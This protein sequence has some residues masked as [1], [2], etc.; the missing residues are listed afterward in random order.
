[1][2][3]KYRNGTKAHTVV[4]KVYLKD[5][6]HVSVNRIKEMERRVIIPGT[7]KKDGTYEV[8]RRSESGK[9]Q[10]REPNY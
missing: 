9:I 2:L 4:D 8:G 10:E 3:S 1:M 7:L 5:Y 6:G